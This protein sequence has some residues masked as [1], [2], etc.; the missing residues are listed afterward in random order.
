MRRERFIF[1]LRFIFFEAVPDGCTIRPGPAPSEGV[2][3]GPLRWTL[4]PPELWPV[5]DC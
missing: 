1:L 5:E 4:G 2:I 3:A